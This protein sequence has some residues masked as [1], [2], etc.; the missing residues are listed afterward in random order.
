MHHN[1][2]KVFA[3]S[4]SLTI[5]FIFGIFLRTYENLLHSCLTQFLKP[6][7]N[8]LDKHCIHPKV[9]H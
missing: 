9:D 3:M 2:P 6:R 4:S 7:L 5:L 1:V 8:K